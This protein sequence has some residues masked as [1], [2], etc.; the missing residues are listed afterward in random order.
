MLCGIRVFPVPTPRL[1]WG[2]APPPLSTLWK[3]DLGR[4]SRYGNAFADLLSVAHCHEAVK[5]DS[6]G[7]TER[8]SHVPLARP[9]VLST[10][11]RMIPNAS[12]RGVSA[13]ALASAR[14]KSQVSEESVSLRVNMSPFVNI[15]GKLRAR[16]TRGTSETD[17]SCHCLMR[18]KIYLY[19]SYAFSV[20]LLRRAMG[21]HS[22]LDSQT[23]ES[24]RYPQ[25]Y[26]NM[27]DSLELECLEAWYHSSLGAY[28]FCFSVSRQVAPWFT[29]PSYI[30]SLNGLLGL[31]ASV[32]ASAVSLGAATMVPYADS[33]SAGSGLVIL[34]AA[35]LVAAVILVILRFWARY[36]TSGKYGADDW[37]IVGGLVSVQPFVQLP[38]SPSTDTEPRDS[39]A[40]CRC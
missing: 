4:R 37:L 34:T 2:R 24:V 33:E 31:S 11:S 5:N 32:V 39:T 17:I 16:R 35:F 10:L 22:G 19:A 36:H 29:A 15:Y 28:I 23:Q 9:R 38:R 1:L 7:G 21:Q 26:S 3:C 12:P 40:D 13:L 25:A 6:R 20:D 18:N 8:A 30:D 27:P 14:G